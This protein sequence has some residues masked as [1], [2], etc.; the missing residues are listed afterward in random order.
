M[1]ELDPKIQDYIDLV[2]GPAKKELKYIEDND[3]VTLTTFKR[4]E[5]EYSLQHLL[6]NRNIKALI[7]FYGLAKNDLKHPKVKS[8]MDLLMKFYR[9]LEERFLKV[10]KLYDWT[11]VFADVKNSEERKREE[12]EFQSTVLKDLTG[13]KEELRKINFGNQSDTI[14][15]DMHS[16]IPIPFVMRVAIEERYPE[17]REFMDDKMNNDGDK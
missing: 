6:N 7:K 16:D 8:T 3:W 17:V 1:A 2:V 13:F 5:S 15:V 11:T 4:R 14:N 10:E 12:I 9:I